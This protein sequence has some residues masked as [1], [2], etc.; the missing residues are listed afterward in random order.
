M[1]PTTVR[2][3]FD[4]INR[5]AKRK[6]GKRISVRTNNINERNTAPPRYD[7]E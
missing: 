6:S 2:L 7:W 1:S 3:N 5:T 4:R